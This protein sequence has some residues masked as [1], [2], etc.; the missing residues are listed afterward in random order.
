MNIWRMLDLRSA[1]GRP[2]EGRLTALYMSERQGTRHEYQI[3]KFRKD[4]RKLWW[5]SAGGISDPVIMNRSY[6]IWWS[7]MDP[8]KIG[9]DL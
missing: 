8:C 1:L 7:Y 6:E 9:G 4:G 2:Q 3:G 5:A